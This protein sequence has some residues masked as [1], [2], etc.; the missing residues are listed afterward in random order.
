MSIAKV[1][2]NKDPV[3]RATKP[4]E[5]MFIDITSPKPVSYAGNKHWLLALD[6]YS[7]VAFSFF[8]RSKDCLSGVM[9][10]FIL[11]LKDKHG[12]IVKIIRC[13]MLAKI[14]NLSKMLE[15]KD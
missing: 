10:D 12:I 4:G 9:I 1:K 6:D 13:D 3:E 11:E 7:D 2:L 15:M 5:R 8:I 14:E